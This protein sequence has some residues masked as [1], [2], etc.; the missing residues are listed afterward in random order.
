MLQAGCA[1]AVALALQRAPAAPPV[2]RWPDDRPFTRLAQNLVTDIAALPSRTT[3]VLLV[4]G[5]GGAAVA[6]RGADADLARRA[7]VAGPVSYTT[8]GDVLGNGW[9]QGGGAVA[10]YAIGRIA[11]RPRVTHIGSDLVRSQILNGLLTAGLKVAVNR[12]RPTGGPHA[13]PSGHTS[14][15]FASAAVLH[16]HFGWKTGV[17]AYAIASFVGWTRVRDREHWV[18]DVVFGASIGLAV[19]H[20]VTRGHRLRDW[21]IVP[22]RTK[23]GAAI[24]LVKTR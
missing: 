4:A 9:V 21:M 10:T 8:P 17:P 16:G 3:L 5:A 18:S 22:V 6:A 19:G 13:F 24:Y 2:E 14:A 7:D 11:G 12:R 1:L 15:T 23:G 20:T